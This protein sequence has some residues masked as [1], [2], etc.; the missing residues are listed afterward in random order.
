M[1]IDVE[2]SCSYILI[3][4]VRKGDPCLFEF[5]LG[6][7]KQMEFQIP[8]WY[9]DSE[10]REPEDF[11]G[12]LNVEKYKG[13]I[14]TMEA[15]CDDEFIREMI[16]SDVILSPACDRPRIHFTPD[17]GWLNDPNGLYYDGE[18][19][20]LY[21][22]HN[23]FSVDWG[24]M[25]WGHARTKDLL[26]FETLPDVLYND[27]YGT[28][29]SGCA[30]IDGKDE[31][32]HGAGTPVFF[33]TAAG[34]KSL[35]SAGKKSVQGLAYTPDRGKTLVKDGIVIP[36]IDVESRDPKVY[37]HEKAGIY[38]MILF[39][40]EPDE[41]AVFTSHDLRHW[42]ESQRLHLP[43]LRECPDLRAVPTDTGE[44][45]YLLS[46]ADGTY[47]TG[48]FD[49]YRFTPDG[50]G[51]RCSSKTSIPYAGQTFVGTDRVL[52]I[53]WLRTKDEGKPYTSAMS[54]PR[55]LSL[56]K[57]KAGVW[58]LIE[59]LPKEYEDAKEILE[60]RTLLT[61]GQTLPG[62]TLDVRRKAAIELRLTPAKD[63]GSFIEA[64]PSF[65]AL[66]FHTDILYNAKD[67]ILTVMGVKDHSDRER[68]IREKEEAEAY[69]PAR[70]TIRNMAGIPTITEISMIVDGNILE[71]TLNGGEEV[72][73]YEL[74]KEQYAGEIE[75]ESTA[76]VHAEV[77]VIR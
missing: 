30:F 51:V 62:I 61:E 26:H 73:I 18:Y 54:L 77:S 6:E 44:E 69:N 57:D 72:W 28:M 74:S 10:P 16:Q 75:F 22:Q 58:Q 8:F 32:G 4:V 56:Q 23:P 13:Q 25:T 41:F 50:T 9:G 45:V 7:E 12:V 60:D 59:K 5:F 70:P 55:E 40:G 47:V 21:F 65:S 36:E 76:A 27:Q 31:L 15:D 71:I 3:P 66:L 33:Y 49:G 37:Y 52:R 24:N 17:T 34:D 35:W 29:Y 19:Y 64:V 2:I 67:H 11:Y 38:Y 20:H 14:L 1:R 68:L 46:A 48:S 53:S 42:D 39:I 63:A 43:G